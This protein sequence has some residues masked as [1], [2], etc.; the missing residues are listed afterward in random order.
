MRIWPFTIT[1]CA[2][3]GST[4]APTIAFDP[5][6]SDRTP[7]ALYARLA[8]KGITQEYP[9]K[10]EH[11]L[12][13]AADLQSP[14]VLHPVFYGSFDW[15]SCVHGYWLL[16]HLLRNHPEMPEAKTIRTF[17]RDQLT[18]EK[19]RVEVAYFERPMAKSFERPY[20]WTW[21][22]K[23]A[24]E[25]HG[26]DDPDA[27]QWSAALEPLVKVIV[28]RYLDFFPKQTY[29][30]RTGVHANTAFGLGFAY[31]YAVTTKNDK[32]KSLI[33]TRAKD[34]F[35]RDK[36]APAHW[37]PSGAD[38]LSPSLCE[39]DLMRRVL[40]RDEFRKWFHAFLPKAAQSEPASLFTPA[41]VTDRSD[42]QLVHLDGLNLSRAWC[43]R[44]IAVELAE[45]SPARATLTASANRHAEAGRKQVA[46]GDY[47]GEHWLAS[48]AMYEETVSRKGKSTLT[49]DENALVDATNAERKKAGLPELKPNEQL[50]AA[51]RNHAV[52]MA[53]Q[54]KLD[55][56][57]D[58][59]TFDMRIKDAGYSFRF[60]GEN[61]AFN[62]QTPKEAIETWMK[63]EFHKANILSQDFQDIGVA[64]AKNA[65]GERYWVQV[66]GAKD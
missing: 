57:L 24:N 19:V 47:A 14:K 13:G 6:A 50:M 53:K 8:M 27:K 32:L 3:I 58:E 40:P 61:I 12:T 42:L 2:F 56:T 34:Y 25:L 11:V 39:A 62:P 36:D 60:S 41:I 48:F 45:D 64:M 7:H 46:S 4:A 20:G 38:F 5:P 15:H 21:L 49:E 51:A 33:V 59:K 66:F 29:P 23:L 22:L 31:D 16:A 10:L 1:L 43:L 63:S 26:W 55:H 65:K 17:F 28:N 9:N 37:E 54:D 30:I 52:N 35:L 18:P 44:S